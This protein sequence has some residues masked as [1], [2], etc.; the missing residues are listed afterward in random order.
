[1]CNGM[2]CHR[3]RKAALLE[4]DPLCAAW[5]DEEGHSDL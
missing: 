1:M 3:R 2:Q 5:V 4:R